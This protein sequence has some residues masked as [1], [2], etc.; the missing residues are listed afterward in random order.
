M[1]GCFSVDAEEFGC[2][3]GPQRRCSPFWYHLKE[4]TR[5]IKQLL[6]AASYDIVFVQKALMTA[7]LHGMPALLRRYAKRL[8]MIWMML[9]IDATAFASLSVGV[10]G[11]PSA[12]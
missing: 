12:N 7:Y 3:T 8:C 1:H 4:T 2:L 10:N 11:R 5:R 9:F 6:Q